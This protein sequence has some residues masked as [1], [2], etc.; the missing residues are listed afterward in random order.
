MRNDFI[1]FI[2]YE[3]ACAHERAIF[4]VGVCLGHA[5]HSLAGPFQTKAGAC[6]WIETQTTIGQAARR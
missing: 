2:V 6:A 1:R 3:W 4:F 5:E